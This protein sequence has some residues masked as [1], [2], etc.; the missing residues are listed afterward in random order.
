MSS[1]SCPPAIAHDQNKAS[2]L[3]KNSLTSLK[4]S[5]SNM[6]SSS[7]ASSDKEKEREIKSDSPKESLVFERNQ[8]LKKD[9]SKVSQEINVV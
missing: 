6:S 9:A 1:A 7:A 5:A 3:A 2:G 4:R 8:G